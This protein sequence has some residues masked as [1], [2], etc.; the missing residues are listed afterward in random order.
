MAQILVK[1]K[2]NIQNDGRD[3]VRYQKGYPVVVMSDE[4]TWGRM[5]RL[6]DFVVIKLP[7]VPVEKVMKYIEPWMVLI[8]LNPDGS[9]RW[10]MNNRRI[11]KI[12]WSD[13]PLSA[14]EKLQNNG[15]LTIKA[16]AS[17]TGNY[18]YTWSQVKTYF[19]NLQTNTDET[20][21]LG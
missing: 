18:D 4:H 6:P 8:G 5:E 3:N 9:E 1:A 15:E 17:Y 14:R 7:N 21:E 11:W 20:E 12:R 19:R 13:L 2:D 16:V 10:E